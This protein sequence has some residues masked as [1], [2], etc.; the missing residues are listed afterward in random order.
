[1]Q[2]TGKD[3]EVMSW[4]NKDI[5]LSHNYIQHNSQ[6][7]KKIYICFQHFCYFDMTGFSKLDECFQLVNENKNKL[8]QKFL[9]TL[10]T[11]VKDIF[12]ENIQ[13]ASPAI[14]SPLRQRI[15]NLIELLYISLSNCVDEKHNSCSKT[16]T[17]NKI[18]IIQSYN[19]K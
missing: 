9:N 3:F 17:N 19:I 18:A 16:K 10:H 14:K 15:D 12:V 1:M 4:L 2:H 13:T 8:S 11:Q 7:E 6:L 5:K